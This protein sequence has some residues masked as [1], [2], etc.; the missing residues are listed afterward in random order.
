MLYAS[1]RVEQR[2]L[3][4]LFVRLSPTARKNHSLL[5]IFLYLNIH[6]N[7][8]LQA[9]SRKLGWALGRPKAL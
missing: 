6:K 8:K 1:D 2:V 3:S 9:H 7:N 5:S 4:A